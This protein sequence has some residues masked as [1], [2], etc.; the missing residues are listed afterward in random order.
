MNATRRVAV[1][2]MNL[3]DGSLHCDTAAN[4]LLLPHNL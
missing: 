4:D 2:T 1:V 3:A